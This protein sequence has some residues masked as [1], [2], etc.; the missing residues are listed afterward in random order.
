MRLEAHAQTEHF[1]CAQLLRG[2]MRV[3]HKVFELCPRHLEEQWMPAVRARP[4]AVC[5]HL[6]FDRGGCGLCMH[7]DD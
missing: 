7:P 5:R 3:L 6:H 4:T 1:Q 2:Q